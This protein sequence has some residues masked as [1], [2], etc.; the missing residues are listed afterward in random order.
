MEKQANTKPERYNNQRTITQKR[1]I[2][3]PQPSKIISIKID[4]NSNPYD[5]IA[6]NID[7]FAEELAKRIKEEL[8]KN[9]NLVRLDISERNGVS[10][11]TLSVKL[12]SSERGHFPAVKAS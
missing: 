10:R 12:V 6:S 7:I 9:S 4:T 1:V 8:L 2:A 5:L 3:K 11:A